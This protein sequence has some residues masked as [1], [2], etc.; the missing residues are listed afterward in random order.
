MKMLYSCYAIIIIV[1]DNV[2]LQCYNVSPQYHTYIHSVHV[3][4]PY[5]LVLLI[6]KKY[7]GS[8][9]CFHYINNMSSFLNLDI[10]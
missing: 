5:A 7:L 9:Q 2:T 4:M 10:L 6:C 1:N 8:S 3:T